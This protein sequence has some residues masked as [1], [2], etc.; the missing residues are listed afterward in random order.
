M[1]LRRWADRSLGHGNQRL[2]ELLARDGQ[3]DELRARAD[4]GDLEA[5]LQ[6]AELLTGQ[7]RGDEA[8]SVLQSE[9]NRNRHSEFALHDWKTAKRLAELLAREGCVEELRARARGGD[10]HAAQRLKELRRSRNQEE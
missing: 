1:L 4:R 7:G 9:L 6:L 5:C 10:R 8:V 3:I 2:A